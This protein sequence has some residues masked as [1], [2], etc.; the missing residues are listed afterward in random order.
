MTDDLTK[1]I[2]KPQRCTRIP[3]L[4]RKLLRASLEQHVQNLNDGR[5]SHYNGGTHNWALTLYIL[6][7]GMADDLT[8]H[9]PKPQPRTR[10]TPPNSKIIES[11]VRIAC[12][13]FK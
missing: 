3:P 9:V 7:G 13:K 4:T 8:K 5:L 6:E 10:I 12:S 11:I 1:Y 2:P